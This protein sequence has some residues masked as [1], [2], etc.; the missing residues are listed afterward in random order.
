MKAT[1]D[2][3]PVQAHPRHQMREFTVYLKQG[4][5]RAIPV[6]VTAQTEHDAILRAGLRFAAEHPLIAGAAWHVRSVHDPAPLDY[7]PVAVAS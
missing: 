1:G 4:S 6:K 5:D 2:T 7:C 3:A